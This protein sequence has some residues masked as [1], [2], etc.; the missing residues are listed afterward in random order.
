MTD[1][2]TARPYA[3]LSD[4]DL[5]RWH[6]IIYRRLRDWHEG[7]LAFGMDWTTIRITNPHSA[8][9]LYDLASEHLAREAS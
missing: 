1:T 4:H 7:G 5:D 3:D 6:R 2:T 9:V 8:R